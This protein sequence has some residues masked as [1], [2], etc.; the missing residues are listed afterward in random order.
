MRET[1][2]STM[3]DKGK[4]NLGKTTHKTHLKEGGK[5]NSKLCTHDAC[6]PIANERVSIFSQESRLLFG[7]RAPLY[8]Y[9]LGHFSH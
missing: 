3:C 2:S 4:Y 1:G 5:R 9:R 7:P 6:K 8:I